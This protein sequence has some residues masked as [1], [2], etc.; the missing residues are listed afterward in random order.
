MA[1]LHRPTFLFGLVEE[2]VCIGI[3]TA[4]LRAMPFTLTCCA[5]VGVTFR[6]RSH[7]VLKTISF[8]DVGGGNECTAVLTRA[9]RWI[10]H[11]IFCKLPIPSFLKLRIEQMLD[12]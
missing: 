10:L 8:C 6:A 1:P 7:L 9:I 4:T 12:D 11:S 2:A 5:D 3:I